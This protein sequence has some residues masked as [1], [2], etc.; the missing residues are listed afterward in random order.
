MSLMACLNSWNQLIAPGRMTQETHRD[1]QRHYQGRWLVA[2]GPSLPT[3][4]GK[5][6]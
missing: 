6:T 2:A 5:A 3:Y 4:E 1:V